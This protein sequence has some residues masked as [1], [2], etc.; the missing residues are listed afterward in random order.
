LARTLGVARTTVTVAYERLAGEGFIGSRVGSGTF[1]NAHAARMR[2]TG[3]ER[4]ESALRPREFWKSFQLG[5][6][7]A[8]EAE[9]DFRTGVPD[10]SLF[11]HDLW[12]KLMLA[13]LR[14]EQSSSGIYMNA[15]GHRGLREAIARHIGV[16]RAV[17]CSADD[18]TIT[19]GTQQAID[20]IARV[21]LSPGDRV[22]VEDP[23]YPPP[24]RLFESLGARVAGVP[25]DHE[26]LIVDAIPK[27]TR[28]IYVTPSHHYPLGVSMSLPRRLALLAWA[29][30][31]D[32]AIV[33][34]DYDSE[35]R[36]GGRPV[37]PL[38]TLDTT[39]RVI[40]VGSFSKTA[41]P[42]LRLGFVVTPSTLTDATEKAK[43]LVDWHTSVPVQA[44]MARF[45]ESGAFTRHIRKVGAVYR[46]RHALVTRGVATLL[47]DHLELIPSSTGLHVTAVARRLTATRMQEVIDAA[48]DAGVA[49]QSLARFGMAK[50]RRVG[51]VLGYG[52]IPAEKIDEGLRRLRSCFATRRQG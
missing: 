38:Q 19:N 31:N 20:V 22:A 7:F 43:F 41:L 34:D 52:S 13:A 4:Q 44:A 27:R 17:H 25:V 48:H 28:L 33:E 49:V 37:E 42:T 40:Y 39:G 1:V 23:G 18:V 15:A 32:A 47:H 8:R 46:R 30:R 45:I 50:R 24:R 10:A 35:F 16:A 12:R 36:F 2:Q 51:V 9:F 26:G 29:E 3:R 14:A 6:V 5:R 11:P 21:M